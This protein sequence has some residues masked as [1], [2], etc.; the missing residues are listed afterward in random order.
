[1]FLTSYVQ[2]FE[3]CDNRLPGAFPAVQES[4]AQDPRAAVDA[5]AA[6]SARA[7]DAALPARGAG[8]YL[9]Q[10]EGGNAVS[11]DSPN[12]AFFLFLQINQYWENI[13]KSQSII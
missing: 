1:M 4:P 9:D 10:A 5:G 6:R 3:S 13:L 8:Q 12:Y 11:Q 7:R 2:R